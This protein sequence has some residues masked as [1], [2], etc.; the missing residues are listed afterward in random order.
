MRQRPTAI[1]AALLAVAIGSA[2]QQPARPTFRLAT[3]LVSVDVSVKRGKMPVPDLTAQDFEL[4]DNGV[5]QQVDAIS[6]EAVPIDVSLVVDTSGSVIENLDAFKFQVRKFAG[7]LRQID[8]VRVV[9]FG[10]GVREDVPMQPAREPLKLDT[11]TAGG[12]TSLN[13]GL[14]YAL[15]WPVE[16]DRRHLVIVF[17]DG[18]DSFSTLDS[19]TIP[20]VAGRV[21]AVLHVVLVDSSTRAKTTWMIGS[22]NQ[23][24][25]ATRA[26]GGEI[27]QLWW[28]AGDFK[29]IFD[30]FRASYVLRFTPRG[31]KGEGWHELAVKVVRPSAVAYTVRA[32]KGYFGG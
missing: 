10:W 24:I 22:R 21:N 8:R 1:A 20:D 3:D 19:S 4:L 12:A 14:L 23:L 31:V 2:Q 17:T 16:V 7:M 15:L 13:D 5:R 30:D 32:R 29:R 18:E 28:A 9:S 25:E 11:V 6:V 27:H 26:S